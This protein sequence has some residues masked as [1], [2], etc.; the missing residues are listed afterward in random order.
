LPVTPRSTPQHIHHAGSQQD[1]R[2][3]GPQSDSD[4]VA[5]RPSALHRRVPNIPTECGSSEGHNAPDK[6]GGVSRS[7]RYGA[8]RPVAPSGDRGRGVAFAALIAGPRLVGYLIDVDGKRV[9][10]RHFQQVMSCQP[11]DWHRI[12]RLEPN[13][14]RF[15]KARDHLPVS[16]GAWVRTTADALTA[17]AAVAG[18][19]VGGVWTYVRYLRQ[20]PDVPR[21]NAVVSVTLFD[22]S[23]VDYLE[24]ETDLQHVSGGTLKIERDGEFEPPQPIVE[25][26]RLVSQRTDIGVLESAP[27]VSVGVLRDQT[28]FGSG[29][30]AR[31][32]NVV[33]L[34][35]RTTDT[36]AYEATLRFVAGWENKA[37]TWSANAIVQAAGPATARG[38]TVV[39][40]PPP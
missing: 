17:I 25:I 15:I 33:R 7:R 21:V 10:D 18:A 26:A 9:L 14:D 19:A 24:V 1:A 5:D 12:L 31:D 34:G 23:G 36:I 16:S 6:H 37:W 22:N 8:P 28:E 39:S 2:T 4:G 40:A 30:S 35:S 27:M 13:L 29:E 38:A 20:A 32:Y 11:A 3:S